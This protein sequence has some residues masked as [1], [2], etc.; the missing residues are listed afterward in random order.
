MTDK[1]LDGI[2]VL[3]VS[4]FVTGGFCSLMMSHLGADVVKVEPPGKG[5][6]LRASGPPFFEGESGYFLSV[7]S[8]KRSMTLNLKSDQGKKILYQLA[9]KSDVF[10]ENFRPGTAARLGIDYENIKKVNEQIVYCSISGFG[11]TGPYKDRPAYDPLI[12][13]LSGVMNIT[14]EPHRPPVKVGVPL[15]DLTAAMWG[16]YGIT[17]AL[18]RRERT[19]K[20]DYLDIAM[21]DGLLPWLTKQAGVYFG[22]EEPSRLGTKDP[23]I[24]PYQVVETQDGYLNL[25]IGNDKLFHTFC[26]ALGRSDLAE[27]ERFK[28]NKGRVE[29][30]QI[31]DDVWEQVFKTRTTDDWIVLLVDDHQLPVSAVLTVG[32]ALNHPQTKARESVLEMDHPVSGK[33]QVINLPLKYQQAESGFDSPPP[34]LGQ[35]TMSILEGLGYSIE[36]IQ[37]FEAENIT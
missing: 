27:D 32:Q 30:R 3:D 33:I 4:T 19:G 29:H 1:P 26:V 28:T 10:L 2:K 11:Q 16:G 7:N 24:A 36:Q 17:A 18:L 25:A 13:A 31:L 15:S 34:T 5:D 22:G 35:H 14:G 20:G 21:L 6:V 12:Q 37:A 9:E 23:V 8:G